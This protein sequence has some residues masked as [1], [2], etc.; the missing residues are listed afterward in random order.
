MIETEQDARAV[1]WSTKRAHQDDNDNREPGQDKGVKECR[2]LC[3]KDCEDY[4][5][6]EGNK[7]KWFT[8]VKVFRLGAKP[9]EQCGTHSTTM[10]QQNI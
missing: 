1:D 4:T 5:F 9:T 6:M 3:E 10:T 2:Q 7:D 8:G